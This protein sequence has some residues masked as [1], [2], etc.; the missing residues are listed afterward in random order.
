MAVAVFVITVRGNNGASGL[1]G[2]WPWMADGMGPAASRQR[3]R[4]VRRCSL[5]DRQCQAMSASAWA[6]EKRME[7]AGGFHYL[8]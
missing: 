1:T 4:G 7:F 8:Q 2:G 6:N 3:V 5:K